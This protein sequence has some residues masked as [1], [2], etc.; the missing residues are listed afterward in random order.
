M[1][2]IRAR[3]FLPL[4]SLRCANPIRS[5]IALSPRHTACVHRRTEQRCRS[6][7]APIAAWQASW[8]E[9]QLKQALSEAQLT[10]E[11]VPI[12]RLVPHV[13]DERCSDW[14]STSPR[15]EETPTRLRADEVI[16]VVSWNLKGWPDVGTTART[17][18]AMSHLCDRFGSS[19]GHLAIMLQEVTPPVIQALKNHAW[20][21]KNFIISHISLPITAA[22]N[23]RYCNMMVLSRTLPVEDIFRVPFNATT[24]CRD[25]LVADL[26]VAARVETTNPQQQDLLRVCTTHLSPRSPDPDPV[27]YRLSQLRQVAEILRGKIHPPDTKEKNQNVIGG[28]VAGDMA[29]KA[30]SEHDFH[31]TPEVDLKDVWDDVPRPPAPHTQSVSRVTLGR[32]RGHTFGYQSNPAYHPYHARHDKFFYTG[33]IETV[34]LV[35][36]AEDIVGNF[37][38]LGLGL[39]TEAEVWERRAEG[40]DRR[41]ENVS[42]ASYIGH[43]TV[44]RASSSGKEHGCTKVKAE[45]WASD[46]FAITVGVRLARRGMS[47]EGEQSDQAHTDDAKQDID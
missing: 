22:V 42:A 14:V 34:P 5:A 7:I 35:N 47:S 40:E 38:R 4:L 29:C 45:I 26:R 30:M 12:V 36:E 16:K 10:E 17:A 23:R 25:T 21:Q 8:S 41:N 32:Y 31:K 24:F 6:S 44:L 20:V 46:H 18:A 13:Y 43:E 2:S 3:G 33:L 15:R 28:I 1:V 19:P 37:G 11:G 27:L 39:K 9:K